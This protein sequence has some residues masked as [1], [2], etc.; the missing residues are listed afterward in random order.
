MVKRRLPPC[1]T[2][3][4]FRGGNGQWNIPRLRSLLEEIL[5]KKTQVRDFKVEHTF[6]NIGKKRM[7]LNARRV[8][9]DPGSESLNLLAIQG[10]EG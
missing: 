1:Q 3:V 7:L 2:H 10:D 6:P 8:Q 9:G 5:P 4:L